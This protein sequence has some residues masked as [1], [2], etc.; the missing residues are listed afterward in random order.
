M[1]AYVYEYD[2]ITNKTEHR[3]ESFTDL[4]E[5]IAR[6]KHFQDKFYISNEKCYV[7]DLKEI[8][9]ERVLNPF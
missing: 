2:I 7:G 3:V 5:F 8:D 6:V 1:K 9:K 4:N